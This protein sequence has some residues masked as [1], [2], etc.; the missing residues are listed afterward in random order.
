MEFESSKIA[1]RTY[2]ISLLSFEVGEY[3]F[4][5]PGAALSSH[6]SATIGKMYTFRVVKLEE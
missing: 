3:G 4:L 1:N 5:P 2:V 6:A